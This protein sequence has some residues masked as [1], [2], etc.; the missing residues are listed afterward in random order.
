[1]HPSFLPRSTWHL[2]PALLLLFASPGVHA[3]E[4]YGKYG[5]PVPPPDTPYASRDQLRACIAREDQLAELRRQTRNLDVQNRADLHAVEQSARALERARQNPERDSVQG[6]AALQAQLQ[7]HNALVMEANQ[8]ADQMQAKAN[9]LDTAQAAWQRECF[10]LKY[11]IED[12]KAVIQ[13]KNQ[14][15]QE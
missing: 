2:L 5:K 12:R 11:R 6:S 8:R 7:A 4:K 14:V 1:M 13:E 3:A 10:H 9:A 15:W